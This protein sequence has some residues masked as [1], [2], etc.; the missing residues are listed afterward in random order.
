MTFASATTIASIL[1]CIAVLVQSIR[2]MRALEAVKGGGLGQIVGSVDTATA[3]ARRVLGQLT[4]LLRGDLALTAQTLQQGKAMVDELTVMT[5][6]ADAI[7]ERIVAVA[8]AS[9][10]DVTVVEAGNGPID[11][12]PA[13]PVPRLAP[14]R[15]PVARA[16]G[17]VTASA[18]VGATAAARCGSEKVALRHSDPRRA[19]PADGA[20]GKIAVTEH[21][22]PAKPIAAQRTQSVRADLPPGTIVAANRTV[23]RTSR[24][25]L[26][27]MEADQ[28]LRNDT[29]NEAA[30]K[31]ANVGV[32]A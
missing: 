8:G 9:N 2:L 25:L 11:Q 1:L 19:T 29:A 7:A 3:E 26:A 14:A 21:G 18:S 27:R 16:V 22:P 13:A 10:R 31:A 4:A 5:G 28:A 12:V 24:R 30:T 20:T 23:A 15:R 32:A 17:V 6:I